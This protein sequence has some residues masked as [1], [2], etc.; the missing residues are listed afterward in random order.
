[1]I[2]TLIKK[3]LV[4]AGQCTKV[5]DDA[6]PAAVGLLGC[7]IMAGIGAAINTGEVINEKTKTEL[8]RL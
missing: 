2:W 6:D 4:A 3:T 5:D 1:M 8:E 7:G